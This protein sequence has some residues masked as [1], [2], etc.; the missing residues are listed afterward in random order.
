MT[1]EDP[2][3]PLEEKVLARADPEGSLRNLLPL[4]R[5]GTRTVLGRQVLK[6]LNQN[7]EHW[8]DL[9]DE[10]ERHIAVV[11]GTVRAFAEQGWAPTMQM[12]LAVY[13]HAL[14]LAAD[15]DMG[16]AEQVLVDGWQDL[17]EQP[18]ATKRLLVFGLPSDAYNDVFRRRHRLVDKAFQHH[19]AGAYDAS[20]PIV[21][22]QIDGLC[23]DVT[24]RKFFDDGK[25]GE[26]LVDDRTL[27]GLDEG[28]PVA[29]RWF[30]RP[31]KGTSWDGTGSRHAIAHGRELAYDTRENST[32]ALVLMLS[33]IEW[34]QP[35]AHALGEWFRGVQTAR[36]AGSKQTD[37]HGRLVDDR[38]IKD[39]CAA[40]RRIST[41]QMGWYRNLNGRFRPDLVEVLASS[42]SGQHGLPD[43]HGVELRV[44]DDGQA[45]WAW[46]T[47]PSGLVLGLGATAPAEGEWPPGEWQY[48]DWAPPPGPP[49]VDQSWG[50]GPFLNDTPNWR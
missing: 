41:A 50:D 27:A 1:A 42:F 39:T 31:A 38:E 26:P 44:T 13:E 33:V 46:R 40:L 19:R 32:K 43:P 45:W 47:T 14:E 22:A 15:G 30:S 48:E 23:R 18:W 4:I 6:I 24:G 29:R 10:H 34:A 8:N 49:G 11:A 3:R 21:L 2:N 37:E 36:N 5:L 28:L 35:Q 16:S 17:L 7:P 9:L 25:K 12:S 20:L